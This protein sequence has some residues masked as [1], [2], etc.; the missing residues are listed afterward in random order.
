MSQSV[1]NTESE[2]FK[3]QD[4]AVGDKPE[5]PSVQNQVVLEHFASMTNS[6]T[7]TLYLYVIS[8]EVKWDIVE[9]IGFICFLDL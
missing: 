2:N 3:L 5:K 6:G 1:L 9:F 7:G 4:S 8:W